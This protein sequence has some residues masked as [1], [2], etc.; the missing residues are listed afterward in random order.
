MKSLIKILRLTWSL[1]TADSRVPAIFETMHWYLPSSSLN[2]FWMTKSPWSLIWILWSKLTYSSLRF[3][4]TMGFGYPSGGRQGRMV[5]NPSS[6]SKS[7]GW[8]EN[9]PSKSV[10]SKMILFEEFLKT[11]CV[12]FRIWAFLKYS[13]AFQTHYH[14]MR[15]HKA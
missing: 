11:L 8:A 6:A 9:S 4:V 14:F 15:L 10:I 7:D 13:R 5:K 1:A 2:N 3:Q 12:C